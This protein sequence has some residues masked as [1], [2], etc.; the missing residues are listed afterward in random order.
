MF[1]DANVQLLQWFHGSNAVTQQIFKSY[2]ASTHL[3]PLAERYVRASSDRTVCELFSKLSHIN[4]H[5]QN[6]TRFTEGVVGLGLCK[7]ASLTVS[8]ILAVESLLIRSDFP[9]TV[10]TFKRVV[11]NGTV[12]HTLHY[13]KHIK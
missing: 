5:C 4:I 7:T 12:M 8:E 10:E 3:N 6:A 1:E 2:I 13:S 9:S 11:V